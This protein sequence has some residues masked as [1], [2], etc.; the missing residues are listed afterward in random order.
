MWIYLAHQGRQSLT[1][2]PVHCSGHVTW[3]APLSGSGQCKTGSRAGLQPSL[4]LLT[5]VCQL[6]LIYLR[7]HSPL[8]NCYQLFKHR[9]L[10]GTFKIHTIT[11]VPFKFSFLRVCYGL[12]IYVYI[13]VCIY[14]LLIY[15]YY[16]P[17]NLFTFKKKTLGI[18]QPSFTLGRLTVLSAE[19]LNCPLV[20]QQLDYP[21]TSGSA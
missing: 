16:F 2:D 3:L 21:G 7:L 12:Y 8:K 6:D 17:V 5:Y 15:L 4:N 1:V 18:R 14:N 9:S 10:W 19:N 20:P 11:S 13:S